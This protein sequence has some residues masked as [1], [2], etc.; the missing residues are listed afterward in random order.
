MSNGFNSDCHVMHVPSVSGG[1][2][3]NIPCIHPT[4]DISPWP[5]VRRYVC[6]R[7]LAV[8]DACADL[9]VQYQIFESYRSLCERRNWDF[10]FLLEINLLK[11]SRSTTVCEI[12]ILLPWASPWACCL[13]VLTDNN[14]RSLLLPIRAKSDWWS[15]IKKN[16]NCWEC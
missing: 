2:Y 1:S 4:S 5:R 7:W 10:F 14:C 12:F 8:K 9:P 15:Q 16:P 6:A 13:R 3:V 11:P